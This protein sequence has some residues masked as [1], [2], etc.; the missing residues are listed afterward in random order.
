MKNH[1]FLILIIIIILIVCAF[2]IYLNNRHN[3]KS[4][5]LLKNV[6]PTNSNKI[7][8]DC[9]VN[10]TDNMGAYEDCSTNKNNGFVFIDGK[11]INA[12][13]IVTFH[14][15]WLLINGIRIRKLSDW[16]ISVE[17]A[18]KPQIPYEIIKNAKSFDDLLVPGKKD[19]WDARMSRW[20]SRNYK[21][22]DDQRNEIKKFVESLPFVERVTF[23]SEDI[24]CVNLKNGKEKHFGIESLAG[25]VYT[26]EEINKDIERSRSNLEKRLAKSD[27]YIFLKKGAEISFGK[28]KSARDLKLMVEILESGRTNEEKINILKRMAIIPDAPKMCP[29]CAHPQA[30]FELLG[31]NW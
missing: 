22:P 1:I 14:K 10:I 28:Q 30:H 16:P 8:F 6:K 2:G 31:E 12:P 4:T 19:A 7:E 20:I 11:Y 17:S 27:T 5:L 18:D 24:M 9:N 3:S 21:N 23:P 15:G 29:A 25:T 13:Y 26:K